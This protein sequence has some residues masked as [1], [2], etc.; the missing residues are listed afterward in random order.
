MR[1]IRLF[2]ALLLVSGV[3]LADEPF[4]NPDLFDG[5]GARLTTQVDANDNPNA[6]LYGNGYGEDARPQVI[7]DH[8]DASRLNASTDGNQ[9]LYGGI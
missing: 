9:D 2:P 3:A 7:V 8:L 6:D 1:T 5:Y 4:G